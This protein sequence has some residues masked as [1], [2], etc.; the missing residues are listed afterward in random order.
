MTNRLLGADWTW[1]CEVEALNHRQDDC[2]SDKNCPSTIEEEE[3]WEE[4]ELQDMAD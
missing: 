4:E 1:I 2:C 3:D